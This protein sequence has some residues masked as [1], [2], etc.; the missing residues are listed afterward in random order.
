MLGEEV[1]SHHKLFLNIVYDALQF[2]Y[3]VIKNR[4]FQN[5]LLGGG[6]GGG[7]GVTKKKES[8]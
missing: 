7:D 6:G 3:R 4:H 5:I 2:G 1:E 8:C